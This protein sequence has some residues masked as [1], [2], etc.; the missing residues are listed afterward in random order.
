MVLVGADPDRT[1]PFDIETKGEGV[2]GYRVVVVGHNGLASP[3]P[4]MAKSPTS[5]WWSTRPTPKVRLTSA[6]YGA[7]DRTG[8]LVI[9]YEASDENLMKRP[10][11]L[12]FSDKVGG[13][14]TTI[15]AG[16]RNDGMYVWPADPKLPRQIYLRI[17]VKDLAGNIGTYVLE[18]PI[19]TQGL[20]PRARIRGFQSLSGDDSVRRRANRRTPPSNL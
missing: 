15:A 19:E 20:A 8:S 10:V 5:S 6:R 11:A 2:F 9:G 13:P 16:L 12:S 1:T 17:D 4:W 3:R 14:W 7:G 18:E